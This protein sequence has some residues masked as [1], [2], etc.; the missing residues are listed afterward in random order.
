MDPRA[1]RSLWQ[2]V[3][4]AVKD[5]RSVLL[6]SH[7]MEECQVLCTRLAIMVNGTLRCLGSAQHLKNRYGEVNCV[8]NNNLLMISLEGL[9][10]AT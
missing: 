10:M 5:A 3:I 2:V 1:R 4:D 9:V 7:S 6:T 8:R